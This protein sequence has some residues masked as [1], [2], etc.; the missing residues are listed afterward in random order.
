M[1]LVYESADDAVVIVNDAEAFG[2]S[3]NAGEINKDGYIDDIDENDI[4][5]I[6]NEGN[7]EELA[8]IVLCGDG[9]KLLNKV[10]Q[11]SNSQEFINNIP[12]YMVI[13]NF[14]VRGYDL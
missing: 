8:S 11:N 5:E 3:L 2:K 7:L 9:E 13:F 14:C 12:S 1:F 10:T 6:M 4:R